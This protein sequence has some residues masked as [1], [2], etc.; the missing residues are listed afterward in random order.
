MNKE[1]LSHLLTEE[2]RNHFENRNTFTSER[3]HYIDLDMNTLINGY[4]RVS[5]RSVLQF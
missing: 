2:E 4:C 1:Y 5:L 3:A